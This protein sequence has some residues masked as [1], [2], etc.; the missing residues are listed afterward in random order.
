MQ[1]DSSFN[2]SRW[3][4]VVLTHGEELLIKDIF[5]HQFHFQSHISWTQTRMNPEQNWISTVFNLHSPSVILSL[6]IFVYIDKFDVSY[7]MHK[8]KYDKQ[9]LWY[10]EGSHPCINEDD[11]LG[12]H[13][14]SCASISTNFNTKV[15]GSVSLCRCASM[16]QSHTQMNHE[17]QAEAHDDGIEE[18]IGSTPSLWGFCL[19]LMSTIGSCR[20]QGRRH[21]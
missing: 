12:F 5:I 17:Q 9:M 21:G 16:F 10:F 15:Q 4:K 20:E 8:N 7:R 3:A 11:I 13:A 1:G 14:L 6:Y 18:T 2:C 19:L